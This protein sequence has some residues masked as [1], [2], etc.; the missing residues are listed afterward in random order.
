MKYKGIRQAPNSRARQ[1]SSF[2]LAVDTTSTE[3]IIPLNR[4]GR[5]GQTA[6][7]AGKILIA[8]QTAEGVFVVMPES[9]ECPGEL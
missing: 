3:R 6:N 1:D 9:L 8:E 7:E 4:E 5:L 2:A